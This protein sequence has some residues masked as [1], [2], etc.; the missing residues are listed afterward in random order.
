MSALTIPA[1]RSREGDGGTDDSRKERGHDPQDSSDTSN[2][3]QIFS[4]MTNPIG[5]FVAAT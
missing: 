2:E 5:D 4:P 1:V 3:E